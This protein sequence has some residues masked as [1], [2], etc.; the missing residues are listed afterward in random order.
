MRRSYSPITPPSKTNSER[1]LLWDPPIVAPHRR[2]DRRRPRGRYRGNHDHSRWWT[3]GAGAAAPTTPSAADAPDGAAAA[4]DTPTATPVSAAAS[5]ATATAT[6]TGGEPLPK[7][8]TETTGDAADPVPALTEAADELGVTVQIV[9]ANE[10][11]HGGTKGVC[12]QRSLYDLTPVVEAKV[13]TNQ[14][15]LAV[16]SPYNNRN[17]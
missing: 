1:T 7:L 12:T 5:E 9:E 14:A 2:R 15:D 10:W 13:R 11:E 3:D 17:D 6:Q 8:E 16:T 4:I